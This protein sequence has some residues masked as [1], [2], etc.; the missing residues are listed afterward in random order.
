MQGDLDK[1][2]DAIYD[3][4]VEVA[5][6]TARAKHARSEAAKARERAMEEAAEA[7]QVLGCWRT[8]D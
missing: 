8:G 7:E 3:A 1:L 4:E 6:S 5:D 2:L